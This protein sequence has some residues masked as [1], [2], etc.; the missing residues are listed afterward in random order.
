MLPIPA[1]R[2]RARRSRRRRDHC[3]LLPPAAAEGPLVAARGRACPDRAACAGSEA[4][5]WR[6]ASRGSDSGEA[7]L[8]GRARG[9]PATAVQRVSRAP[10]GLVHLRRRARRCSPRGAA[11]GNGDAR[12]PRVPLVFVGG[13]AHPVRDH[14]RDPAPHRA[15][16]SEARAVR[17]SP[18][19]LVGA[20][21]RARRALA[22][23][24]LSRRVRL[25]ARALRVRQLG[26]PRSRGSCPTA[27]TRAAR[28]SSRSSSS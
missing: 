1:A 6:N 14:A 11:H 5:S 8:N 10:A 3:A 9:N 19:R 12:R 23:R 16:P 27:G 26:P 18:A 15:R 7:I 13:R 2:S 17:T 25:R 21:A 22:R 20:L 28:H 24:H 4:G